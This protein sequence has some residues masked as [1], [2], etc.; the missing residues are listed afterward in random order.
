[1][2]GLTIREA[3]RADAG[4]ILKFITEL[5]IYEKAESEVQATLSDIEGSLFGQNARAFGLICSQDD[6]PVG[7]AVYFYNYSTWLGRA[8]LYLEDIYV[9]P[10]SRGLGAGKAF[11]RSLAK[12]A[13]ANQCERFEWSVLNWNSSAITF[14]ESLGAEA[15]AEWLG[16]RLSGPALD[17]LAVSS[18]PI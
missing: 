8:G 12:I 3:T 4:I 1:M 9:T 2:T 16:Y 14:Y 5:A 7:F 11:M 18:E 13:V 10:D 6:E 17:A 15:K